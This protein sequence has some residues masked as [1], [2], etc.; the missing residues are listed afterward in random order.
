[1]KKF[2]FF[3]LALSIGIGYPVSGEDFKTS[4][5]YLTEGYDLN[6][7]IES[8]IIYVDRQ[9]TS[10]LQSILKE[11]RKLW[12]AQKIKH[13]NSYE[14]TMSFV[15]WV[16]FGYDTTVK[17]KN[18][19]VV[20]RTVQSFDRRNDEKSGF[21]E[22]ADQI[23]TKGGGHQARTMEE[24]YTECA[25]DCLSQDPKLNSIYL[26]FSDTLILTGCS[27]VPKGC[28]DDCTRGIDSFIFRWSE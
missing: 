25:K 14:Y 19:K 20:E 9:S 4:I 23:N 11:S 15:S 28:A 10:D 18:G 1:M 2:L 27:Y 7:K 8:D 6:R 22:N 5:Y 21:S 26:D 12:D 17:V 13:D 24:L 3:A 16:G